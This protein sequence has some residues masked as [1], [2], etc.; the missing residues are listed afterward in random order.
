M[1]TGRIL[2]AGMA[3]AWAAGAAPGREVRVTLLHTV[4]LRGHVLSVRHRELTAYHGGLLRCATAVES[5][6]G[7]ESNVVWVDGG[8]LTDGSPESDLSGGLL[9]VDAVEAAGL[10]VRVPGM[11]DLRHPASVLAAREARLRVPWVC[12]NVAFRGDGLAAAPNHMRWWA[13]D[14]DG[15]R[16]VVVGVVAPR[17]AGAGWT[18]TDPY[19]RLETVL[20]DVRALSPAVLVLAVHAPLFGVPGEPG[21][22]LADCA[23]RFPEFDVLLGRSRTGD[24]SAAEVDGVLCVSAG[25]G[26]RALARVNLRVDSVQCAVVDRSYETVEVGPEVAESAALRARLGGS[27]GRTVFALE[28]RIG[29]AEVRVDGSS[30]WPGQSALL[31][32]IALSLFRPGEGEIV[33]LGKAGGGH[34]ASGPIRLKD[35]YR[36]VPDIRRWVRLQLLPSELRAV[37][38]ENARQLGGPRFL[39]IEGAEYRLSWEEEDVPVVDD[40]I[41]EDGRRPHGRSRLPVWCPASLMDAG[42][43]ERDQLRR[44]VADPLVRRAGVE[45]DTRQRVADYVRRQSPLRLRASRGVRMEDERLSGE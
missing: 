16:V 14:Y 28:E 8:G 29:D 35:V 5:I 9:M 36:A 44:L 1:G 7:E 24:A 45:I 18:V 6:R 25:W 20:Q 41:L 13:G 32:L 37:L 12:A 15:I 34:L 3:L 39:G 38:A 23:R 10:D 2:M 33:L 17:G 30:R 21:F 42:L 22:S 40:L 11:A 4:D 27:L 19:P 26:G 31:R 43:P